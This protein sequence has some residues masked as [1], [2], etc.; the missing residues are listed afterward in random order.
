MAAKL[1]RLTHKVAITTAPSER[2]LYH[3]QFSLQA[4]SPET[5]DY[6]LVQEAGTDHEL[7][8]RVQFPKHSEFFL[9]AFKSTTSALGHLSFLHNKYS[10]I[11]LQGINSDSV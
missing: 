9:F 4:A 7:E 8:E 1:T 2:E 11:I 5:F 6:T 3:L 10:G